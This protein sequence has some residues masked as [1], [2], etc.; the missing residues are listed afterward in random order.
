ML[1]VERSVISLKKKEKKMEMILT[2]PH[3]LGQNEMDSCFAR[4]PD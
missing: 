2:V 3:E 4:S 1:R